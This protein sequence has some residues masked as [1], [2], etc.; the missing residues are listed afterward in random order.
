MSWYIYC[1][2]KSSEVKGI[3]MW[4]RS[5]RSRVNCQSRLRCRS[6]E[7]V[8]GLGVTSWLLSGRMRICD[9]LADDIGRY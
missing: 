5:M 4:M 2:S 8:D 3:G 7:P 9:V 1:W 6:I